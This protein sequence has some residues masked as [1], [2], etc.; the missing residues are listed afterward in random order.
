MMAEHTD[1]YDQV[2]GTTYWGT[3]NTWRVPDS[4]AYGVWN[5]FTDN[6]RYWGVVGDD[7]LVLVRDNQDV[8]L[9]EEDG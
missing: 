8:R 5:F 6:C 7:T 9:G 2:V 3:P 1:D 4:M